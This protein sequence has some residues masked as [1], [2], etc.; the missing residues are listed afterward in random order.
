MRDETT[1]ELVQVGVISW[2]N[3]EC[4]THYGV[5][6]DR[7]SVFTPWIIRQL[8]NQ[9]TEQET[10]DLSRSA[11]YHCHGLECVFDATWANGLQFGF[12]DTRPRFL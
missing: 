10:G 2:A 3:S 7:V 9:A 11:L 8:R 4:D 12:G 1:G 6:A 5:V